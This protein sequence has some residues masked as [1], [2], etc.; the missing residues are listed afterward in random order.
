MEVVVEALE[1]TIAKIHVSDWIDTFWE[2]HTSWHLTV[3][4]G[5]F[6]LNALHMP[7]VD[8]HNNFF[9]R[10]LIDS[11]EKVIVSLVYE[12]LLKPW[13]VD[14]NVLN[15]PVHDIWVSTIL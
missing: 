5:P 15:I 11:L 9:L 1:E 6:M 12:N 10:A 14:L 4:V 2:V 13:E 7:L 8:N 3:S